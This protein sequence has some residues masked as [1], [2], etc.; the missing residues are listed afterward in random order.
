MK[1]Y[2]IGG[3]LA[4]FAGLFITS[5]THDDDLY[6]NADAVQQK[7]E[8]FQKAFTK[9]YGTIAS[10]QDWG[11]DR[12][13]EYETTPSSTRNETK[14]R[15][16]GTRTPAEFGWEVSSDYN[17]T[18]DKAYYDYVFDWLQ[19]EV[20]ASAVKYNYEFLSSGPFQFSVIFSQTS[21]DD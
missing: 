6:S 4:L 17:R 5:C 15:D 16:A 2:L 8:S 14:S 7:K 1:K 12:T 21:G 10:N 20:S 3:A 13:V 11:F 18:F 19:E 9:A